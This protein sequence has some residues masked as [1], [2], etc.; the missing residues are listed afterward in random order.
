MDDFNEPPIHHPAQHLGGRS[1]AQHADDLIL[2]CIFKQLGIEK[3]SYLDIGAFH[4]FIISNTYY[5][6]KHGS[7]GINCEPSPGLIDLFRTWRPYDL[8]LPYA[9]APV[10]GRVPLFVT[11]DTD[12]RDSLLR[13]QLASDWAVEAI[14]V[15]AVTVTDIVNEYCRGDFPDLL[16]IDIEGFDLAVLQS[17]QY[18]V[19]APKVII[20]EAMPWDNYGPGIRRFLEGAGYFFCFR[21][22][23]NIIFVHE[24]YRERMF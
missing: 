18:E 13:A 24:R 11:K 14:E 16:S 12:G 6:Y 10:R 1:Y 2:A 21:A 19:M 9:V 8:N 23:N 17:I 5:F 22:I 7:R 4:P 15:E 3:P 20:A